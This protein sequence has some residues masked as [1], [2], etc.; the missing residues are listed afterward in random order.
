MRR[1]DLVAVLSREFSA[2]NIRRM[3]G[4][5]VAEVMDAVQEA[6]DLDD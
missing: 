5:R 4:E 6:L 2:L 3:L 1:A